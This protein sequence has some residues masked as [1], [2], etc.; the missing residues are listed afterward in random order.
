MKE[1]QDKDIT[2]I[3][4]YFDLDLSE[5]EMKSFDQR[6]QQDAVF[7]DKVSRY[8]HSINL[9]TKNYPSTHQKQRAKKWKQLITEDQASHKKTSWK[10]IAG[11]ATI[12]LL[13]ISSWYFMFPT[14]E[15]DLNELA[16]KAWNK[17]VGFSDYQVRN[18]TEE[19]PK[20]V[21]IDAF[22]L[23]KKKDYL[24]AIE[25]LEKY[26]Y[27][28]LYYE[29]ALLI[30][31]LSIHKMGNSKEAMQLLDSLVNHPTGRLSNEALWYKGLIYL[32][33][34]DLESAKKYLEIPENTTSEIQLK[35]S[36]H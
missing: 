32:D 1:I 7:A 5:K 18:T 33:L 2:L 17:N 19:N 4:R 6:L 34:N 29:D 8:Q 30:R 36:N 14:Q 23:Y 16:Q 13:L 10:W 9:I 11:I 35:Q 28:L 21:V 31:A 27:S 22:K 24:S 20:Q 3:T 26:D 12:F 15:I 25:T